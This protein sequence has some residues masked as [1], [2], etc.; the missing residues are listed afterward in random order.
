MCYIYT[1]KR[2]I[3]LLAITISAAL[4]ARALGW[5][6][7]C[8][9]ANY[10]REKPDYTA[11]LG[12]QALMGTLVRITDKEDYWLRVETPEPYTAWCNEEAITMISDRERTQ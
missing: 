10:L 1:M 12:T 9:S 5:G 3:L 11:E 6:I 2:I 7:V 8:V 4:S